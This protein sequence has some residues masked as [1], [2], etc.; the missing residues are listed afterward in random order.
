MKA[1]EPKM[2]SRIWTIGHSTRRIDI[3]LSL[4]EENGIKLVAD[5][6]MFPGSKRYPQFGRGA[7]AESLGEHGIAMNIFWS[8]AGG[9]RRSQI[10]KT[11]PGAMKP[12][13]VTPITW[14]P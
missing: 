5:V 8:L 1:K 9:E 11:R 3:F 7:L 14:K 10:Q 4:L 2:I 13:A 12:S 6:R